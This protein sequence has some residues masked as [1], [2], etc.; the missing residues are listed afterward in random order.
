MHMV[1]DLGNP[2]D[3]P[4][5]SSYWR[6]LPYPDRTLWK[7]QSLEISHPLSP[8]S[9]LSS[10]GLT[11][12]A[13]GTST[14]VPIC[15]LL[16][17]HPNFVSFSKNAIFRPWMHS[18]TGDKR[19]EIGFMLHN[20]HSLTDLCSVAISLNVPLLISQETRPDS[21]LLRVVYDSLSLFDSEIAWFLTHIRNCLQSLC[22]QEGIGSVFASLGRTAARLL[23]HDTTPR[24]LLVPAV[25]VLTSTQMIYTRTGIT[26]AFPIGPSE[27]RLFLSRAA[28]DV[29]D[30]PPPSDILLDAFLSTVKS[31]PLSIAFCDDQVGSAKITY[32]RLYLIA[33][34]LAKVL[35]SY[36]VSASHVVPIFSTSPLD[37]IISMIAILLVGAAYTILPFPKVG[38]IKEVLN[39]G[40]AR[41]PVALSREHRSQLSSFAVKVIDPQELVH[42]NHLRLSSAGTLP[43][44]TLR[45]D[46]TAFHFSSF[47]D[48]D[49]IRA[50]HAQAT[51]RLRA[52]FD[53]FKVTMTSR[54]L[55]TPNSSRRMVHGILWNIFS[56][57]ATL[58]VLSSENSLLSSITYSQYSHVVLDSNDA[59]RDIRQFGELSDISDDSTCK[60]PILIVPEEVTWDGAFQDGTSLGDS[61]LDLDGDRR[62]MVLS[63][64]SECIQQLRSIE[65][66]SSQ[67]GPISCTHSALVAWL[68]HKYKVGRGSGDGFSGAYELVFTHQDLAPRNFMLDKDGQL[69]M[70]DWELA[71]W[72]PA[73]FEY[74][75]TAS[76]RAAPRDWI[77]ALLR[78][79]GPFEEAFSITGALERLP[80]A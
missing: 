53:S 9:T 35:H 65:C 76:V 56:H 24:G 40:D 58:C 52:Q 66:T 27:R 36:H 69:W 28:P 64:V 61:W 39:L 80:F 60:Q 8:V 59:L 13:S 19:P 63:K 11:L 47:E 37:L 45:P 23:F 25:N 32:E 68:N 43:S 72:Y 38:K 4:H 30:C 44:C 22:R 54:V 26:D 42:E 70:M 6:P 5:T 78:M 48:A 74:A 67:P 75:C 33:H 17:G 15:F 46:Q 29:R 14:K 31:N 10:I 71:G 57:G 2:P 34:G 3:F 51:E 18:A 12:C 73:Y 16:S 41:S 21:T 49:Y 77:D 7:N 62:S 20:N 50:T 79:L 55:V 1:E